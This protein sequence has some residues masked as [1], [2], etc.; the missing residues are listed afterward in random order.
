M[1]N[2]FRRTNQPTDGRAHGW[3]QM[4]FLNGVRGGFRS[5]FCKSECS[6]LWEHCILRVSNN[7]KSLIAVYLIPL[8]LTRTMGTCT[9]SQWEI[10]MD[11]LW[12]THT[13][14]RWET[15]TT[16]R[17]G[18]CTTNRHLINMDKIKE[19]YTTIMAT[20]DMEGICMEISSIPQVCYFHVNQNKNFT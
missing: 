19:A 3:L 20:M 4:D 16:N 7:V 1:G 8:Q 6:K 15:C 12:V 13:V 2:D 5:I 17:S 11:N 14:N 18:T 10:H 9:I